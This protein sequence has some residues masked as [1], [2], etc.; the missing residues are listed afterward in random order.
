MLSPLTEAAN[1]FRE[2]GDRLLNF[3]NSSEKL[4]T[5]DDDIRPAS[6]AAELVVSFKPSDGLL[7]LVSAFRASNPDFLIFEHD[8]PLLGNSAMRHLRTHSCFVNENR[9]FRIKLKLT[10]KPLLTPAH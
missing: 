10:F 5:V 1:K 3:L 2:F 4:F 8:E 6:G 9:P 7:G